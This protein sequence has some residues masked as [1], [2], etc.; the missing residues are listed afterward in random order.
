M[1]DKK[2]YYQEE[3]VRRYLH[4]E[5]T[6]AERNAFER[7][8]QKDPFLADAVDGLSAFPAEEIISD[9]QSLKTDIQNSRRSSRIHI[10]Y[11]A[12]SILVIVVS[13]FILFNIDE[14]ANI[15]VTENTQQLAPKPQ[16]K[17]IQEPQILQK[18]E[19]EQKAILSD[20]NDNN[21]TRSEIAASKPND[22][23]TQSSS[24]KKQK[25]GSL[26]NA[27]LTEHLKLKK[28]FP[29]AEDMQMAKNE[30]QTQADL[31]Q[32]PDQTASEEKPLIQTVSIRDMQKTTKAAR[33]KNAEMQLAISDSQSKQPINVSGMVTDSQGNPLPGVTIS[34]KGS[35]YGAITNADGKYSIP[36]VQ[37][38]NSLVYSFIGKETQ[39][40]PVTG[41]IPMNITLKNDDS[42]LSEVVVVGYGSNQKKELTGSAA[43]I[44]V[45]TSSTSQKA[46]PSDGWKA[47]NDYLKQQ[48]SQP[49]LARTDK[50]V[51]IRL[52]FE[53]DSAGHIGSFKILSSDNKG[54]N[55]EAIRIIQEGP[56]WL[57][58]YKNSSPYPERVK[59]KLVFPAKKE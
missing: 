38:S 36:N 19:T 43:G 6:S 42:S 54:L 17:V 1:S 29:L 50:R 5:M 57:P 4:N 14:K 2:T 31:Q 25:K 46:I 34:L 16:G 47:Y 59:L 24:T 39:E 53:V 58:A 41:N 26:F 9:I 21:N 8:M 40:I 37:D 33:T 45:S 27:N 7:E 56:V 49:N 23:A 22:T 51:V 32:T 30:S 15:V 55:N 28:S 3:Q 10:W 12:A 44:D 13:T 35:G 20:K 48:L 11:A 18:N 52:E